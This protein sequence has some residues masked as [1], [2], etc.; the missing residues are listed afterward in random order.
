MAVLAR[1]LVFI[2]VPLMVEGNRLFRFMTDIIDRIA[3]SPHPPSRGT[4]GEKQ[5]NSNERQTTQAQQQLHLNLERHTLLAYAMSF[6]RNFF[7]AKLTTASAG[8]QDKRLG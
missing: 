2:A 3:R 7:N 6:N 4:L 5:H 8:A 1:D